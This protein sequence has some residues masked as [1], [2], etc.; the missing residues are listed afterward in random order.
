MSLEQVKQVIGR[1]VLDPQFRERLLNQPDQVMQGYDLTGEEQAALQE[2]TPEQF[3]Q[4]AAQIQ[5]QFG[6]LD[7]GSWSKVD[8]LDVAQWNFE[9]AWPS[10]VS[11]PTPDK[12]GGEGDA[13]A[14]K[15]SPADVAGQKVAP[16]SGGEVAVEQLELAHEGFTEGD[17]TPI[18]KKIPGRLKWSDI[19]LKRGVDASPSDPEW[20]YVPV[21]RYL[22]GIGLLVLIL[23]IAG[24]LFNQF[25]AARWLCGAGL[26]S[27]EAC[28]AEAPPLN[29]LQCGDGEI[30]S[31]EQCDGDLLYGCV[32]GQV[33]SDTCDCI[34]MV[35]APDSCGNGVKE[36]WEECDYRPADGLHMGCSPPMPVCDL[37]TCTCVEVPVTR[38]EIEP[39]ATPTPWTGSGPP[40]QGPPSGQC[41]DGV[42]DP[43]A[44]N[45]D[46]CPAD[47]QCT[48]DGVCNPGEGANCRDCGASAGACG[49]ACSDSGQCAAGLSCA[50]GICW[51]AC[52]CGGDCASTGGDTGGACACVRT[53]VAYDSAG[54]CLRYEH[55]DCNGATC[56]P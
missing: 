37:D 54:V 47:C 19:T 39:T 21:R 42:C 41:G 16:Q 33:C 13:A 10:K 6:P 18:I 15:V 11:G 44:E 29:Q 46:I 27:E 12:G 43:A 34:W 48:D 30:D 25:D 7:L 22:F 50:G 35:D 49:S 32:S 53:C 38:G 36:S 52:T 23:I 26:L 24:F 5:Q 14:Q 56:R 20:K 51:D 9:N 3:D 2:I 45:S 31:G 1:A 4:L 28:Q 55:R 40:P 8:G 17:S